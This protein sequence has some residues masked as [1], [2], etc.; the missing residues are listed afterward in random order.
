MIKEW[1]TK[2]EFQYF[3][4][5]SP[6][7]IDRL[8][9]SLLEKDSPM[10]DNS[11]VGYKL[12][13]KLIKDRIPK[14]FYQLMLLTNYLVNTN[15]PF[16]IL[17]QT[18]ANYLITTDWKIFGTITFDES[19][20]LPYCKRKINSLIKKIKSK[21]KVYNSFSCVEEDSNGHH[22]H[23]VLDCKE[24]KVEVIKHMISDSLYKGSIVELQDYNYKKLGSSYLT[25]FLYKKEDGYDYNHG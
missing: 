12:N 5:D 15:K 14:Y 16:N 3:T 1:L 6:R 19:K 24:N 25:K 8:K 20:N 7:T 21:Y 18:W 13:Y 9:D 17:N 10:I 2:R 11:G 22:I 23:F 4:G